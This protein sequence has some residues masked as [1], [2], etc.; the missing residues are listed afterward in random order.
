VIGLELCLGLVGFGGPGPIGQPL[1]TTTQK[2]LP[3]EQPLDYPL[4]VFLVVEQFIIFCQWLAKLLSNILSLAALDAWYFALITTSTPFSQLR[5]SEKLF[6][7]ARLSLFLFV[8][9]FTSFFA[10]E[11]PILFLGVLFGI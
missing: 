1:T 6:F 11:T 3:T 10:T 2:S 9:L 8:A 5:L 4:V 7:M